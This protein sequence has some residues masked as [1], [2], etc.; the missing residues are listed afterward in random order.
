M[1]NSILFASLVAV[2]STAEPSHGDTSNT[3][4]TM[5]CSLPSTR[6]T[7][8]PSLDITCGSNEERSFDSSVHVARVDLERVQVLLIV[9]LFIMI[10]VIAKLGEASCPT[11]QLRSQ[12]KFMIEYWSMYLIYWGLKLRE[13]L[14]FFPHN[15][16]WFILLLQFLHVCSLVSRELF[17]PFLTLRSVASQVDA[18]SGLQHT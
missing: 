15:F 3:N 5:L 8:E 16:N 9:T 6:R 2:C 11:V 12:L 10:V 13:I 18:P 7:I 17:L 14:C 1:W 4:A